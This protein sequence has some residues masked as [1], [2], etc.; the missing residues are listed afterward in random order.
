MIGL[1]VNKSENYFKILKGA[2]NVRNF[3]FRR[4]EKMSENGPLSV[5]MTA[6]GPKK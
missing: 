6:M 3:L 4:S 2:K 5:E 1:I